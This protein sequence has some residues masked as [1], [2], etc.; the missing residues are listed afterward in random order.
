MIGENVMFKLLLKKIASRLKYSMLF[1]PND[2]KELIKD[3]SSE[4]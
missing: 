3:T 4:K 1:D 2:L